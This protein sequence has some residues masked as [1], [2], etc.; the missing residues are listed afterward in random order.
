MRFTRGCASPSTTARR[1]FGQ[2]DLDLHWGDSRMATSKEHVARY[3]ARQKKGRRLITIEVDEADLREIVLA[4]YPDAASTDRD[5]QS[6][7]VSLFV[8]DAVN[9]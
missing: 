3:R 2:S 6:K 9:C 5:A 1:S 7:A 8:S 4:G